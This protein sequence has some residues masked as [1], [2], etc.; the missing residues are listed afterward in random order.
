MTSA[1]YP[2][3]TDIDEIVSRI[4]E[5]AQPEQ[6]I[7]FGSAARGTASRHSD[8]DFLV[9]KA[10]RYNSR[11]VAGAIYRRMRGIV[12]AIDLVIVTPTEVRKYK[13]SPF[14]IV[15]P[16]LRE[17]KVVYARKKTVVG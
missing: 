12:T 2:Q 10:G 1:E 9:I 16:A 13:D 11:T 6:V 14:S 5:V 4:M 7:L 17:G 3:S 15:C 8:L